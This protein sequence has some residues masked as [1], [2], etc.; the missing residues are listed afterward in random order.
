MKQKI[1]SIFQ[2]LNFKRSVDLTWSVSRSLTFLTVF[3]LFLENVLWLGSIYMLKLLVDIVAKP[4]VIEQRQELM[5]ALIIA[6][7]ISIGYACIKSLSG[8]FSELQ[9]TKVNHYVDAKIHN[10]T[11]KLD[12]SFYE[13]PEYLDI[14]KRARE[15]G[16][17]KPFAVVNSL[18][19]IAKNLITLASIGYLL[20]S[21]DWK[22][23]PLLSLFVLPILIGRILFS[24]RGFLLY[25]KNTG[26]ERKANYLSSLLTADTYAKEIRTFTLGNYLLNKY[27]QIRD[28]LIKQQLTLSRKRT[29]NELLTTGFGTAAFFG[30]TA[31]IVFGTFNGENTVGDIAVFLVI[32]PQSYSIMQALVSGITSLYQNNMYVTHIYDL[33][34]LKPEIENRTSE[35]KM[36]SELSNK[37][38][39][40]DDVTFKYPH[41][42]ETVLENI[43]LKIPSGK[44]VALVGL[45]GAGKT[46]L[47]KLLC[48]LYEPSEGTIKYN[49]FDIRKYSLSNTEKK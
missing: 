12:Y 14:L 37:G 15:A 22:L 9:A 39:I 31:Y 48:K 4:N 36:S 43:S 33:F 6:G 41:S 8:Y 10:H 34:D 5:Q 2:K 45:N 42:H 18:F 16:V 49:G 32:F 19:D 25:I 27:I 29:I 35:I 28:N 11:I 24:N 23:L 26:L 20:I 17:D 3:L 30:I 13:D 46:T 44:I 47:I 7:L 40:I 21:I 38:L 1:K